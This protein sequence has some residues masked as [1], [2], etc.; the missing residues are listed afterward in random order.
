MSGAA[1]AIAGGHLL[2]P[3]DAL[4][5]GAAPKEQMKNVYIFTTVEDPMSLPRSKD[6]S[7][8]I[9]VVRIAVGGDRFSSEVECSSL[10]LI[11]VLNWY[12][13]NISVC[14]EHNASVATAVR[15]VVRFAASPQALLEPGVVARVLAADLARRVA[16]NRAERL[17]AAVKGAF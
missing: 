2:Y 11:R 14:A 15:N 12:L 7:G 13:T 3:P 17:D 4:A 6:S 10:L 5:G 8:S 1:F 16:R 9:P